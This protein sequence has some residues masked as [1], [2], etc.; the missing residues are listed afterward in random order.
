[1]PRA[2]RGRH[3]PALVDHHPRPDPRPLGL[4][5]PRQRDLRGLGRPVGPVKRLAHPRIVGEHRHTLR[6]EQRRHVGDQ[7]P[8]RQDVDL[9]A[10]REV[11]VVHMRRRPQRRR[12]HGRMH[13]QPDPA[14]PLVDPA[15]ERLHGAVVGHV[16]RRQRRLPA[17]RPDPVVQLLQA[18]HRARHG[19]DVARGRQRLGD[20]GAEAPRGAG[21]EGGEGGVGLHPARHCQA[22]A[23]PNQRRS[24]HFRHASI[25][26]GRLPCR[27]LTIAAAALGLLKA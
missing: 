24:S 21:D 25:P 4:P 20:G 1:M 22:A 23:S 18:P 3:R 17:A 7:P 8:R 27:P 13:P 11:L 15:A 5:A 14:P 9:H 6:P 26:H 16:H 19:D 2:Q 10:P 12:M